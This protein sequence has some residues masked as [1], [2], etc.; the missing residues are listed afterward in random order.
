M[1]AKIQHGGMSISDL[2][3]LL[4]LGVW[5]G[6]LATVCG[7]GGGLIVVGC[8]AWFGPHAALALTAP[9]LLVSHLHRAY[10][11]RERLDA[12][13]LI[14]FG[15]AIAPVAFLG[16]L[17][18][19]SLDE[20][21]LR[22]V[23][24]AAMVVALVDASGLLGRTREATSS[25]RWLI[26]GGLGVGVMMASGGGAGVLAAP[27]LRSAGQRGDALVAS[28]AVG[29]VIGHLARVLAYRQVEATA[30]DGV[31]LVLALVLTLALIGGNLLGRRIARRV[32][33]RTR[34]RVLHGVVALSL[35]IALLDALRG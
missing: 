24:V 4:T 32:D 7:L 1:V 31:A 21:L 34:E 3:V 11:L 27:V 13:V 5:T 9:S 19:A 8:A 12:R 18:A 20:A 33:E 22:W 2:L 23:L 29:A 25:R 15:G 10:L 16:S 6:A 28:M 35:V 30:L 14:R 26:P 17:F